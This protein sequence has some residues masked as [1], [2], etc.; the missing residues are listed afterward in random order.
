MLQSGLTRLKSVFNGGSEQSERDRPPPARG[1]GP[2][3]RSASVGLRPDSI[4]G[5]RQ[6]LHKKMSVPVPLS[7]LGHPPLQVSRS[8][9]A[10]PRHS[11]GCPAHSDGHHQVSGHRKLARTSVLS[12]GEMQRLQRV[13]RERARSASALRPDLQQH[14][15]KRRKQD[16]NRNV[17]NDER[18]SLS[19]SSSETNPEDH[20]YEEIDSDFLATEEETGDNFLLSISL[21]RQRNL[22]FYGSAGWDFGSVS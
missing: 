10:Y 2:A 9:P 19:V 12:P 13:R 15:A 6:I 5:A 4:P 7:S 16:H 21:E 3:V 1:H 14:G 20:I 22:K 11:P 18:D 17:Y 8:V